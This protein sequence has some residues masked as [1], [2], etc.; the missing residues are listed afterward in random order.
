MALEVEDIHTYYGES[1]VLHGV[2]LRVDPGEVLGLLGRNG[3]GKTTLLAPSWASRRRARGHVRF[4]GDDITRLPPYRMARAAA[5]ALVPQGRAHLPA[6]DVRGEPAM[7]R[8]A[9]RRPVEQLDAGVRAVSAP[10]ER[11]GQPG[12]QA[13]GRRAADAGDR[14]AR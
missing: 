3:V 13:L 11:R 5:S 2:S 9:R 10:A 6:L 1:H 7:R 14:R 4:K 8:P 12:H